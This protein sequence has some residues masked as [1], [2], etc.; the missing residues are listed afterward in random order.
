MK[1]FTLL[2]LALGLV[3]SSAVAQSSDD[4]VVNVGVAV[5]SNLTVT[6][7]ADLFFGTTAVVVAADSII[8]NAQTLGESVGVSNSFA[9]PGDIE[10][11]EVT[12]SGADDAQ[13]TISTNVSTLNLVR[14][15][16]AETQAYSIALSAGGAPVTGAT[17]TTGF[18]ANLDATGDLT[19]NVGGILA[20]VDTDPGFYRGNF[21]VTV[22]YF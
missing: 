16:G 3:A 18:T 15:G 21:T 6:K 10:P 13:V 12:I 7:T 11:G 9:T 19:L 22:S 14:D 8:I 2:T 20:I 4:A 1:K 5:G 17:L